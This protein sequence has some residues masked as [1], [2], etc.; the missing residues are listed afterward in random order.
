MPVGV[1][2]LVSEVGVLAR[3]WQ[4]ALDKYVCLHYCV[5]HCAHMQGGKG[6]GG[7]GCCC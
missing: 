7:T 5:Q 2:C 4:R 6:N 3:D 1:Q